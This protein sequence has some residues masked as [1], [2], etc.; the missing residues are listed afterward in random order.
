VDYTGQRKALEL[1]RGAIAPGTRILLVDE[2][3]ETGAQVIAAI[4]LIEGQG[5]IVVGVAT[6]GADR[7][8]ATRALWEDYNLQGVMTDG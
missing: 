3:V 5:G 1:R 8:E 4:G 2:W 7:N 6:I